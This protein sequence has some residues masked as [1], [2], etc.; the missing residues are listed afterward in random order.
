MVEWAHVTR[1]KFLISSRTSKMNSPLKHLDP[2]IDVSDCTLSSI[3]IQLGYSVREA[4]SN[5]SSLGEVELKYMVA[6]SRSKS[7]T[8]IVGFAFHRTCSGKLVRLTSKNVIDMVAL[9]KSS[10]SLNSESTIILVGKKGSR[11]DNRFP[12]T[13]TPGTFDNVV[14]REFTSHDDILSYL[15]NILSDID[16]TESRY[17]VSILY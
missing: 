9:L 3:V 1:L 16:K 15:S 12:F 2:I 10:I 7:H 6:K 8:Y 17:D 13:S 14:V 4:P 11:K 5:G